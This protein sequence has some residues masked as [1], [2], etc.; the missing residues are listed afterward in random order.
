MSATLSMRERVLRTFQR[1]TVD[2]L[3]WQPR[4]Y[5]WYYGTGIVR[6]T[7][8]GAATGYYQ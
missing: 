3:M 4:A 2:R 5:C 8:V 6:V 1:Q 7:E